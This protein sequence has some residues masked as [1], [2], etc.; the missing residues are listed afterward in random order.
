MAGQNSVHPFS[1]E[2][3]PCKDLGDTQLLPLRR[4]K[5]WYDAITNDDVGEAEAILWAADDAEKHRLINGRLIDDAEHSKQCMMSGVM[6]ANKRRHLVNMD[7]N[8]P[9]HLAAVFASTNVLKKLY[10]GGVDVEQRNKQGGNIVS[11]LI[12]TSVL[13]GTLQNKM[14]PRQQ[15]RSGRLR[16]D[17]G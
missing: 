15:T 7:V 1:E 17:I 5:A 2:S 4:Y 3:D 10:E 11:C 9:W 13:D 6:S 8:R 16:P 12:A 14:V